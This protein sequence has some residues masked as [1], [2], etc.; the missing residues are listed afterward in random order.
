MENALIPRATIHE[1][2][3]LRS[4]ALEKFNAAYALIGEGFDLA[5]RASPQGSI[6]CLPERMKRLLEGGSPREAENF[7]K[8]MA[9]LVDKAVWEHLIY[10]SGIDKLMDTTARQEFRHQLVEDPPEVSVE[11]CFATMQ[12]LVGDADMIFKR[13]IATAF[14]RLD[15]RF[16]SHDGFKIGS[17]IIFSYA[18]T[19][20]Q[21]WS[22]A[23]AD[24]HLMDVERAFYVLDGKQV[25]ER[26]NGIVGEINEQRSCM[27]PKTF[28]AESEYFKCR[29]FKN[30]NLHVYFKRDDLVRNVN[31]LLAEYYGASIGAA[32]DVAEKKH[33]PAQG[34][35]KN[36]GFFPTPHELAERVIDEAYLS[37]GMKVL[38]PNAG[39]GA[40]SSLAA[41]K[42]CDVT[43]VEV[44]PDLI[45]QLEAD[46]RY[47]TVLA[48]DFLE[49]NPSMTGLFERI[50]MNPPFDRGR[51]VDHVSHALDFL[52]TGGVLVAIMSSGVEFRSDAKTQDFRARVE[53]MGGR[54]IDLP[55]GSFE[56]VGTMV[57]TV[58]LTVRKR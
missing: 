51:D 20:Y 16:R 30:G 18:L 24:D 35:A 10:T 56:S 46:D 17:R 57:N 39:T 34:L 49:L 31:Q 55:A 38:E 1:I 26:W 13:G 25:P 19:S 14:S 3:G 48:M 44:Q 37:E 52:E 21:A 32:A 40:L 58:M 28:T 27:N 33:R 41:D 45:E 36:Y 23:G 47:T 50:I 2:V 4:Q 53:A 8:G 7:E 6:P 22:S 43:C 11:N 15:R 12:S 9:K 29:V 54:F 5:R 42:K